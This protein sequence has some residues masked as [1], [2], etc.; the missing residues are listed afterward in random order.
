MI[1]RGFDVI[2]SAGD[3]GGFLR[4]GFVLR[5]CRLGLLVCLVL[6]DCRVLILFICFIC[7]DG[8]LGLWAL[9]FDLRCYWLVWIL[10]RYVWLWMLLFCCFV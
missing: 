1:S 3:L 9:L 5:D 10:L 4:L 6:V 7:L 8:L 2:Y